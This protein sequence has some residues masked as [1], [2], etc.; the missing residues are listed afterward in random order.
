MLSPVLHKNSVPVR[1]ELAVNVTLSP[2][3]ITEEEAVIDISGNNT[4]LKEVWDAPEQP[5]FVAVTEY[6]TLDKGCKKIAAV[7]CPVDQR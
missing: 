3:Q 7:V 5:S 2:S 6:V 1:F 4:T